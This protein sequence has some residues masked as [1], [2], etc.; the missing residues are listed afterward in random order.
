M[1][2]PPVSVIVPSLGRP[3]ELER[4]LVGLGQLV[5]RPYEI[6]VVACEKGAAAIE[7]HRAFPHIRIVPNEGNGISAARNAGLAQARGD[8]V[9]FIDDDA[10]PEPTWLDH[11]ISAMDETG[12]Q[13]AT[14]YVRGRNGISY[15]WRGRRMRRDGF[16][17][18]LD[19]DGEVPWIPSV[20][21]GAVMLE[22]TNMAFR[23]EPIMRLGGFDPAYRFYMDDADIA[24]RCVDAGLQ[25]VIVPLAQ[26]HH[27]FAASR[28]RRQ[29]RMPADLYDIGRS[30][31]IFLR[32]HLCAAD[33]PTV[34]RLHRDGERRRVLRY[35]VSG[36]GEPRDVVSL[37]RR[38]DQGCLDGMSVPREALPVIESRG[39]RGV[40]RDDPVPDM[41]I[42]A[43]GVWSRRSL[44]DEAKAAAA[45]GANVSLFRFGLS[46]LF[47][48]VRFD[49][50]GYW[51]QSGGLFGRS[52]RD[53]PIF[54]LWSFQRRL[55][56]EVRRVAKVRGLPIS[57]T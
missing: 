27:G 52:E 53:D 30:L 6:V 2:G 10:V 24:L 1:H 29:D 34:L 56:R 28:L 49:H 38:F 11:L 14:G 8:I 20:E 3:Y 9:A 19:H 41:R 16:I 42:L 4:C 36:H 57:R 21:A 47:H 17:D 51:E 54:R 12:A 35:M 46:T 50:G 15:Q 39:S 7:R 40:F 37:L 23:R 45:K 31:A 32:T 48:R 18:P 13:A 5:Y 22:G 55:A 26:V 25:T 33:T 44:R 43:G